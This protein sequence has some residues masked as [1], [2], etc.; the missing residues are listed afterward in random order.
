MV[1]DFK[2]GIIEDE[3]RAT[4]I[5][6]Q[7]TDYNGYVK[8]GFDSRANFKTLEEEINLMKEEIDDLNGEVKKL[9]IRRRKLENSMS[10][11]LTYPVRLAGAVIKLIK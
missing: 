1:D 9:E 5:E 8:V 4:V 6:I 3:E 11:K 10:W 7:E 2:N